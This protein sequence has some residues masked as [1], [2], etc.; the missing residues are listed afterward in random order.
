MRKPKIA[1]VCHRGEIPEPNR[2][3]PDSIG[4]TY[5]SAIVKAGGLPFLIPLDYPLEDLS[6]IRESFDG[7]LLTGG[8]DVE[9]RRYNGIEHPSVSCVWPVRDEIE[10]RLYRIA[11]ETGWPVFGICRG[12]QIMNVAAGGKLYSD[13]SDQVPTHRFIHPQPVGTPRDKLVH[14]V[15]IEPDTLLHRIIGKDSIPVNSFHHQAVSIPGEGMVISAIS[16]DGIIEALEN[17]A[18]PFVLGVQWH[19]ECMQ[20]YDDQMKLF[21]A[22]TEACGQRSS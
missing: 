6:V 14:S 11:I 1:V 4:T 17:P 5:I 7:L 18:H 13:I 20:Q 3:L 19:P 9:T 16:E 15:K 2:V 21:R 8:G 10:T 22:F 12:V